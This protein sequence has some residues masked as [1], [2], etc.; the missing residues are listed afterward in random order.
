MNLLLLTINPIAFSIGSIDI[1]W[2]GILIASGI[3]LGYIVANK[4]ADKRGLPKDFYTDFLMWA[5]PISIISARIYYVT[6]E[7][8]QYA[9]NPLRAIEIW[10]GGIA[11][12][13]GLI[14]AILTTIIYCKV[15]KISFFKVADITVPSLLI[16]QI[17]GRWGNFMN[18]E[19]HG[20]PVSR[21]FL[22]SLHLPNWLINQM[23]IESLSSYVHP[24]FLYESLWNL[25]GLIIVLLIRKHLN[26]GEVF[27]TYLI[28]Y[29][30]GRFYIEGM[31]T[32][33][34]YLI[35]ELRSAQIVSILSL[36]VAIGLIVYR[37]FC[38]KIP[39]KYQEKF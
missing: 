37:R 6:M 35:G 36:I 9:A 3:L 7:W 10:N 11:I 1:R 20:G 12:H 28:W 25:V 31:R 33:S 8:D 29:A 5:I 18:Q 39:T 19:A 24:T 13:G 38:I 17:I 4:E 22:E 21:A 30:I 32:D 27:A 14:G 16:G 26:R 2:Y 15:K 34:L 23:Y